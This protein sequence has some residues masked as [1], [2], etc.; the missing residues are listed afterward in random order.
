MS[1][2]PGTPDGPDELRATSDILLELVRE[3]DGARITMADIVAGLQDRAFGLLMLLLALPNC[4][5]MPGIP[6][7]STVTGTPLAFF[8]GQLALGQPTPWLPPPL[9]R[10][11]FDRAKL[12]RALETIA[13]YVKRVER[14]L[15]HRWPWLAT[16]RGER[17]AAAVAFVLAVILAL[18]IPGGNLLPAWA[19]VF[20]A[21]G[22]L[23]RDGAC[24]VVGGVVTVIAL[25][26]VAVVLTLGI[27]MA[28][29][30]V[31]STLF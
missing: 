20:F 26:I 29:Y 27:K 7:V 31:T 16:G 11:S 6:F 24:V 9:L 3:F 28:I 17:A 15:R 8:A 2:D 5:P 21:L 22:I 10:Q 25:A 4:P 30:L 13:P 19:I 14:L 1:L 12:L 18:P 23:E